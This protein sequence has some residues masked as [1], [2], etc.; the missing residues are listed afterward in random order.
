MRQIT[1]I[2]LFAVSAFCLTGCFDILEEVTVKTDG[3]GQYT[4]KIDAS[5]FSEQMQSFAAFDSTG[6]MIPKMKYSLDSTFSSTWANYKTIKGVSNVKIDTSKAYVYV[7]TFDFTNFEALNKAIGFGKPADQQNVY[8]WEK[9][10]I[11]RKDMPLNMGDM[12]TDDESQKE[13]LKGFLQDMKYTTIYHLPND[14]K[15]VS[16]KDAKISADKKTVTLECNMLELMDGK[17]KVNNDV[18]YW[19]TLQ[20]GTRIGR[21]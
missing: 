3:S 16:N 7:L 6:E 4:N 15:K 2:L 9:G 5:K 11:S 8:A 20:N 14:A 12:K 17:V 13:M 1:S 10:K 18:T 19:L 21:I